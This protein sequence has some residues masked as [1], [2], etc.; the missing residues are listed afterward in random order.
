[1]NADIGEPGQNRGNKNDDSGPAERLLRLALNPCCARWQHLDCRC[2]ISHQKSPMRPVR[3]TVRLGLRDGYTAMNDWIGRKRNGVC[4][5]SDGWD[6]FES[7]VPQQLRCRQL[8]ARDEGVK[9]SCT[10]FTRFRGL[11]C[12][13]WHKNGGK[14]GT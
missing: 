12:P 1:M 6:A 10:D 3:F 13:L 8:F 2:E 14:Q 4:D 7:I 5:R 11:P 9:P